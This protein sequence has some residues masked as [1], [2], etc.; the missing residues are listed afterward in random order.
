MAVTTSTYPTSPNDI[1]NE[2][3]TKRQDKLVEASELRLQLAQLADKEVIAERSGSKTLRYYIKPNGSADRVSS[4][5]EGAAISDRVNTA[6]TTVEVSLRGLGE[7]EEISD[8]QWSQGWVNHVKLC[9]EVFAED[10]SLK[11]DAIVR[12]A[13][14]AECLNTDTTTGSEIF[15][16]LATGDSSADFATMQAG[17][18][19]TY[20]ITEADLL[21]GVVI[22][23][24]LGYK[25]KAI[26]MPDEVYFDVHQ[27]SNL[28]DLIKYT[29]DK[30]YRGML[31]TYLN[32]PLVL[33]NR[34]MRE[35][36]YGT[37]NANGNVYSTFFIADGAYATPTWSVKEAG[38][39][40]MKPR[41]MF[42]EGA[43][44]ANPLAQFSSIGWKAYWNVAMLKG[45]NK[46][47]VV[48][49]SRSSKF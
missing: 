17:T 1:R 10:A 31:G 38:K 12:D 43:D 26:V 6:T 42:V 22:Q 13:I 7:V 41:F 46:G 25:P 48:L 23:K 39:D 18:A 3:I 9:Q 8:L 14:I 28:R 24:R 20:K 33:S 19:A 36:T 44:S 34:G 15:S 47:L 32:V 2:W 45:K 5:T 40:P 27:D 30:M 16:A 35:T 37:Y 21:K 29:S 49:R 11:A 4:L